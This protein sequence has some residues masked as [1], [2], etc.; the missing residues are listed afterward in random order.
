VQSNSFGF[1]ISWATNVAVVVQGSANL[2]N[3]QWVPLQTIVLTNGS[4]Y[5]SDVAWSNYPS[6]F[7]RVV[8]YQP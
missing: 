4:T 2:A 6:R 8:A 5:F 1:A 3:P 7:Y